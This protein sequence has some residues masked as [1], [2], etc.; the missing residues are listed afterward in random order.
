MQWDLNHF[1]KSRRTQG[2]GVPVNREITPRE[3]YLKGRVFQHCHLLCLRRGWNSSGEVEMDRKLLFLRA[4][5]ARG[6]SRAP[7]PDLFAIIS[8]MRQQISTHNEGQHENQATSNL[9]R[10]KFHQ[11]LAGFRDPFEC[12]S[13]IEESPPCNRQSGWISISSLSYIIFYPLIFAGGP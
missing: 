12:C 5:T 3:N 6:L 11:H 13:N 8:H 4:C 2:G 9:R 7:L 1:L 10:H